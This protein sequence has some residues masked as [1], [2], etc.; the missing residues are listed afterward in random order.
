MSASDY[1]GLQ[2]HKLKHDH[3]LNYI[4]DFKTPVSIGD[5]MYAKDW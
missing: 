4:N 5:V 2:A 3:F 1:N